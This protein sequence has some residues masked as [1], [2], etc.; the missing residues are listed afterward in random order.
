MLT[1]KEQAE[2]C[3]IG[4]V[5]GFLSPKDVTRWADSIIEADDNPDSAIID[6]SLMGSSDL[7]A[8]VSALF[9]V[10]GQA[11]TG[12]VIRAALG[13]CTDR[14][15]R[16]SLTTDEAAAILDR[17]APDM[18]CRR[19][20]IRAEYDTLADVKTAAAIRAALNE[21]AVAA[22]LAAYATHAADITFERV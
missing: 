19:C 7:P 17:L 11:D 22:F 20:N 2:V 12:R 8:M 4:L 14:I 16:G 3:R 1:L 15:R 9:D 18:S 5:I 21:N 10:K 6:I 13:V